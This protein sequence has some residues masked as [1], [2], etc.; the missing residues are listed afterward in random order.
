MDTWKI[1]SY[2]MSITP[3]FPKSTL[4]YDFAIEYGT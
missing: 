4:L 2:Q 1:S 3:K